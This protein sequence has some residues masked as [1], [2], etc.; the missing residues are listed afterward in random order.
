MQRKRKRKRKVR[1]KFKVKVKTKM[2]RKRK[3][4]REMARTRTKKIR[5][6]LDHESR[7]PM[8]IA[9]VYIRAHHL[10][11]PTPGE[12]PRVEPFSYGGTVKRFPRNSKHVS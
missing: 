9:I 7:V 2:E 10:R 11:R 5:A 1:V 6:W 3:R 4:M 8:G 12:I